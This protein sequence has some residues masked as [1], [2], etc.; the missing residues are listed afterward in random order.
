MQDQVRRFR[1][2]TP[3]GALEAVKAA[4]GPDAVIVSTREV[5]GSARGAREIEVVAQRS[6]AP[7]APP[8]RETSLQNERSDRNE[9]NER[10]DR[11]D[12]VPRDYPFPMRLF[13]PPASGFVDERPT[14]TAQQ[15]RPAVADRAPR[16]ERTA[17]FDRSMVGE[18]GGERS[19]LEQAEDRLAERAFFDRE[20]AD[21]GEGAER[22]D[23]A[24]MAERAP[25]PERAVTSTLS[26]AAYKA[27]AARSEA[28]NTQ[29]ALSRGADAP[30]EQPRLKRQLVAAPPPRA[31]E[32]RP[33]E[34]R[35][36]EPRGAEPHFIEVPSVTP[37]E[38]MPK[39]TGRATP[40]EELAPLLPDMLL[41]ITSLPPTVLPPTVLPPAT[42][43]PTVVPSTDAP[44]KLTAARSL[45]HLSAQPYAMPY[46]AVPITMPTMPLMPTLQPLSFEHGPSGIGLAADLPEP[47][48]ARLIARGVSDLVATRIVERA[49][50]M[51]R[52]SK[53]LVERVTS[54]I[55]E[56]IQLAPVPWRADLTRNRRIISLVGPTG[57]G[58]TTTIAKIAA[59]AMLEERLKVS[60]VT[61][62]TYR[63]G[64]IEQL[65][66]YGEIMG[67]PTYVAR[68]RADLAEVLD[69]CQ[70]ADLVLID[71]AGRS[72][73]ETDG[74]RA[75]STLLAE[76][77]DLETHVVVSAATPLRQLQHLRTRYESVERAQVVISKVDEGDGAAGLL[78][79]A[80]TLGL[81][82]SCFTDGQ[83][84][85][86]DVHAVVLS[87]LVTDL[88]K[89]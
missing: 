68:T 30:A 6:D 53:P 49:A 67:L 34:V 10:S 61:V 11:H 89:S 21:P 26:I 12:D 70:S 18:R 79:A 85:P 87:S 84:V 15:K 54:A 50:R 1:A 86:E 58:K 22:L 88:V 32:Q 42:V 66:R 46:D 2:S 29:R 64:A 37:T 81:P 63:V 33:V 4:F 44:Q 9:R 45:L 36:P 31:P 73:V 51:P 3:R 43:S 48:A 25:L 17:A 74:I 72:P 28:A 35:Q 5:A 20:P 69:H 80:A 27:A 52:Q 83:R 41:P 8:P 16:P 40:R 62:D 78:T 47:I 76:I 24:A 23:R 14:T 55:F 65:T 77:E 39:A 13:A 38:A 75:Q 56:L 60:L 57:V 7:D 19:L 82:V 59:R 71:T